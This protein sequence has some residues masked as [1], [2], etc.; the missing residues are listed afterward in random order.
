[1]MI[2]YT[3]T[4]DDLG[5]R[6]EIPHGELRYDPSNFRKYSVMLGVPI[7]S[8]CSLAA[9]GFTIA[10]VCGIAIALLFPKL[11]IETVSGR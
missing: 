8:C 1:M 9:R 3:N 11:Y 4:L 10:L 7:S 6:L 2:E 5:L